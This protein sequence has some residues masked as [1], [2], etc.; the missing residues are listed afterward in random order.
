MPTTSMPRGRFFRQ[1][2]AYSGIS[3][4][5]G[6]HQVAQKSTT[7]TLPSRAARL[8]RPPLRSGRSKAGAV[9]TWDVF[10]AGPQAAKRST[11]PRAESS[12]KRIF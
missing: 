1:N 11:T 2:S 5:Q 8:S 6:P 4:M 9:F 3:L 10:G 7:T 12:R